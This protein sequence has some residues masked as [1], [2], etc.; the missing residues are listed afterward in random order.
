MLA[1]SVSG[2]QTTGGCSPGP[3]R[4][5]VWFSS[6]DGRTLEQRSGFEPGSVAYGDCG[7]A[8]VSELA[9]FGYV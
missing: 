7:S 9:S 1:A 6:N 2:C 8:L 5:M 4:P 3:S